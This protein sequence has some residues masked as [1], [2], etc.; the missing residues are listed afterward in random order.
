M[1]TITKE[2]ILLK[3][4]ELPEDTQ[5]KVIESFRNDDFFLWVRE[6]AD[7]LKAFERVFPVK[8]RDYEYGD[9][10]DI[11]F[12]ISPNS[13]YGEEIKAFSGPRLMRYLYNNYWLD[14]TSPKIYYHPA[15]PGK[16]RASRITRTLENCPLTGYCMDNDILDPI[17]KFLASPSESVTFEDLLG[18]CLHS[19]LYAC[20]D[21]YEYWSSEKGIREDIDANDYDFTEDGE[22]Y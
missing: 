3:F 20:R 2:I 22:I 12:T 17:F 13:D 16:K 11:N 21:D 8:V 18:D 15:S 19:W 7:T 10:N 9:R 4:A 5:R 14:I 1:K 6:N